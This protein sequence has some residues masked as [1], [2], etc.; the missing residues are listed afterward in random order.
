MCETVWVGICGVVIYICVCVHV[1]A[2]THTNAILQLSN[3]KCCT[4]DREFVIDIFSV[5]VYTLNV[6]FLFVVTY[7]ITRL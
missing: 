1:D 6:A 4:S 7:T 2:N 3:T 5:T